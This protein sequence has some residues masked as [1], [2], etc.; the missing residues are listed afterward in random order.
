MQFDHI[1]DLETGYD[2]GF[3]EYS[4][5][6]TAWV[7]AGSLI[8]GGRAYS[9]MVLGG[10][11]LT[12]ISWGYTETQLNLASLAG[13]NVYFRFRIA[14]DYVVGGEGWLID[15]LRVYT[16]VQAAGPFNLTATA[17]SGT[18][19]AVSWAAFPG[20]S[21]YQ[22]FRRGAGGAFVSVGTPVAATFNDTG[23]SANKAYEY[24]VKAVVSGVPSADSN[25]DLATTIVF[26]DEPL[27]A[28][29][30]VKRAHVEEQR[31]A[32]S[33]VRAL[34]ALSAPVFTDPVL[35]GAQVRAVHATEVRAQLDAALTAL[36]R[37]LP[38]WP[39]GVLTTTTAVKASHVSTFRNAVK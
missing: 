22:V 1:L 35:T 9:S 34:A 37:P 6:G 13:Q 12:G 26:T 32:V 20:A 24:K 18:S 25:V 30:S 4:T 33:A 16:C 17:T 2:G 5:N 39:D 19:V 8:T 15:R 36:A 31:L 14:T 7:D 3:I 27:L 23:V 38:V 10:T 28:G 11:A 21:S 29:A